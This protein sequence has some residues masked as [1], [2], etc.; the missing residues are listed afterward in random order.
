MPNP[1]TPIAVSHEYPGSEITGEVLEFVRAME[2]YQRRYHR[3]YPTWSE[4]LYVLRTLG[5]AKQVP[6]ADYSEIDSPPRAHQG[7]E[8]TESSF[9]AEGT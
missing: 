2:V 3:R 6:G 8:K 9:T 1:L 5:Y 4:V 7:A